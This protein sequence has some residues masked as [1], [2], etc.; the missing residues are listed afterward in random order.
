MQVN[1]FIDMYIYKYILNPLPSGILW[2]S[3]ILGGSCPDGIGLSD[4]G[5]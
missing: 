2:G 4:A 3:W 1:I 5:L